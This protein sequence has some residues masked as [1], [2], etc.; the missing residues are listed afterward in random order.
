[1]NTPARVPRRILALAVL[2]ALTLLSSCGTTGGPKVSGEPLGTSTTAASGKKVQLVALKKHGFSFQLPAEWSKIDREGALT[3]S[4]PMI[5]S[6]AEHMGMDPKRLVQ[7]LESSAE[8]IAV[9]D[10]GADNGFLENV[11][12]VP[13]APG[14]SSESQLRLQVAAIG[15]KTSDTSTVTTPIGSGTT[16]TYSLENSGVVVHG[17]ALAV[18]SSADDQVLITV[19]AHRASVAAAQLEEI[20][21]SLAAL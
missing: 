13:L 19:S 3:P 8:L 5:K 11:N 4:N 1:M 12:V 20:Q 7:V 14:Q 6:M 21:A 18:G 10:K 17:T 16:I 15:G 9:T 2:L